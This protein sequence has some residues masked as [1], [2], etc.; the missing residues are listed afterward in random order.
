LVAIVTI[1]GF[2][3]IGLLYAARKGDLGWLRSFRA[4]DPKPEGEPQ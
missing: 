4:T 2:A 3:A 1:A